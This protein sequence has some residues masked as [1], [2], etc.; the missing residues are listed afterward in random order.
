[1]ALNTN[2]IRYKQLLVTGITRSSLSQ[3]FKTM[4]LIADGLIRVDDLVTSRTTLDNVNSAIDGVAK[5][6]GLKSAILFE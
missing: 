1:M 4:Q 3:Y 2:M 6:I 5:G